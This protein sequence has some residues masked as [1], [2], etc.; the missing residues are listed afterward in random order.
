MPVIVIGA[1]TEVGDQI[2]AALLP[3]DGEVRAFVSDVG[4]AGALKRMGVKVAIGDIS[5]GS[6]VGAAAL[7]TFTAVAI[8]LAAGDGRETA[9]ADD[10]AGVFKQWADGIREAGVTRVIVV[11]EDPDGVLTSAAPEAAVVPGEGRSGDEVAAEVA[12]LDDAAEI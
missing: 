5:D 7:H 4:A 1:D 3:R 9:F 11:G 8:T 12:R 6:H 2:I 10:A